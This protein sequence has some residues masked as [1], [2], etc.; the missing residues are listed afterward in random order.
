MKSWRA[1]LVLLA[2]LPAAAWA[3][4]SATGV[5]L[6]HGKWGTP[7]KGIV[8]VELDLRGAGFLVVA[9]E[10]AW[11]ERRAYDLSVDESMAQ[12]DAEVAKLRAR[13]ARK[14]VVGGQSLGANM[15]LAYGARHPDLAGVIVMAPGHTP[16]R[17]ARNPDIAASLDKAR[18]LIAAGK[19]GAFANFRDL[20]QGKSRDVSARPSVY[21]SYFDPSGPAVMPR[22][23]A[24]LSP[25]VPL[26]WIVGTKDNMFQAGTAFAFDRAPKN[27]YSRY[28]TVEA[29]HFATPAAARRIVVDWVKGLP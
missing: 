22:N 3:Q 4:P 15:A 2:L 19:D 26:L 23:A 18:A 29:D 28:Q 8:P 16:E 25:N 17:F 20:N 12:I 6:M 24:Q 27:A 13:G 9:P 11:S 10:M 1:L 7:D 14:I 5:I 21:L